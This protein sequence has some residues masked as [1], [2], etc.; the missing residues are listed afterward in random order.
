MAKCVRSHSI[1]KD[2]IPWATSNAD[3]SRVERASKFVPPQ[4]VKGDKGALPDQVPVPL[5]VEEELLALLL[6]ANESLVEAMNLHNDL[7][8]V[9][10]ER[11][12]EEISRRDTRMDRRT[13]Q[14]VRNFT[15]F[16]VPSFNLL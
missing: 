4:K 1:V 10:I 15:L 14:Q 7:E 16:R 5:T 9:G 2:Q 8:R 11:E 3:K 6:S 13:S 12:A